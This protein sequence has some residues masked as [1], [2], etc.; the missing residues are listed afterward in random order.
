MK[1]L[2]T[3]KYILNNWGCYDKSKVKLL[4]G[5]KPEFTIDEVL[6]L[7][8]PLKDKAWFICKRCKL[9]DIELRQFAI[10][11]ALVVLP[12]YENKYPDNKAP[13][14]AIQAA[15][16][17]LS[18]S[19]DIDTLRIK[20]NAAACAA[21]AAACAAYADDA[22]AYADDAA[23]YAAYAACAA[24]AAPA[25]AYAADAA[26]VNYKDLLL[27]FFKDFLTLPTN[28]IN[29]RIWKPK[30]HQKKKLSSLLSIG[31]KKY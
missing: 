16:D 21:Y 4:I 27:Q 5:S 25:A 6:S 7:D 2:F 10:G 19:I 20:R 14:E 15:K 12:I 9:T 23:A 24:Y 17:Y 28:G 29:E 26:C 18:G 8:V 3:N 30:T 13:R 11:C 22:A 1:T 31:D